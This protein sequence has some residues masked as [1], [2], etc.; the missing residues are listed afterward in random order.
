M[1]NNLKSCEE[2]NSNRVK[3]IDILTNGIKEV[4]KEYNIKKQLRQGNDIILNRLNHQRSIEI[5]KELI[6]QTDQMI[7][8]KTCEKHIK[9]SD[10]AH[11][12]KA[13]SDIL[14]KNLENLKIDN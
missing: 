11:K 10:E 2:C 13:R 7:N 9:K 14:K 4:N 12:I 8:I 3:A 1:L 6:L 5:L